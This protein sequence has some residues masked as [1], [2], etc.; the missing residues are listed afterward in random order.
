M[1]VSFEPMKCPSELPKNHRPPP[2]DIMPLHHSPPRTTSPG[3]SPLRNSF[4]AL[5]DATEEVARKVDNLSSMLAPADQNQS[6][7]NS[8]ELS[9]KKEAGG[10]SNSLSSAT[11]DEVSSN[12][13]A[14]SPFP[15]S[16]TTVDTTLIATPPSLGGRLN[17]SE[18]LNTAVESYSSDHDVA[19]DI[20][21]GLLDVLKDRTV[22]D[23]SGEGSPLDPSFDFSGDDTFGT[24]MG[25]RGASL[26]EVRSFTLVH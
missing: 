7:Q 11:S 9:A 23:G 12:P 26:F 1:D 5:Q 17:P 15:G 10:N 3:P 20:A 19:F 16:D 8:P 25:G 6:E 14:S 24:G 21:V 4:I 18:P 2:V 13:R 22:A